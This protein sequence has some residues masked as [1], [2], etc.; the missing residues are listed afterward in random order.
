[1]DWLKDIAYIVVTAL[2]VVGI[3]AGGVKAISKKFKEPFEKLRELVNQYHIDNDARIKKIQKDFEERLRTLE[4][5]RE[6]CNKNFHNDKESIEANRRAINN[7]SRDIDTL[8]EI[9]SEH[10]EG[11]YLCMQQEIK[12]DHITLLEEWQRNRAKRLAKRNSNY[13][14]S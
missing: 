10:S 2:T 11:L 13:E 14:R 12:G 9:V 7:N 5:K 4:N 8:F 1:M 6:F 3:V